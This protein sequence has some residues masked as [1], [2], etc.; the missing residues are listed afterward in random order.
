[1]R[2]GAR[3]LVPF[4]PAAG[5]EIEHLYVYRRKWGGM[6]PVLELNVGG[7]EEEGGVSANPH[8]HHARWGN[9]LH[10]SKWPPRGVLVHVRH[11]SRRVD[12]AEA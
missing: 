6:C 7:G 10:C 11:Q 2:Y 3:A 5:T 8:M 4:N 9:G 1:M 12:R